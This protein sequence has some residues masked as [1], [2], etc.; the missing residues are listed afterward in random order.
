MYDLIL[1]N[2]LNI[3]RFAADTAIQWHFISSGVPHFGGIKKDRVKTMKRHLY[4]TIESYKLTTD[5]FTILLLQVEACL[6]SRPLTVESSDPNDLSALTPSHFLIGGPMNPLPTICYTNIP[7]NHLKTSATNYKN[8]TA[9]QA[10]V[11]D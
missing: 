3:A 5:Q 4:K 10:A 1:K 2:V 7:I 6:N 9:V 8:D 11:T